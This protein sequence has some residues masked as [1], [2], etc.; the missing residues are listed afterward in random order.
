VSVAAAA[1]TLVGAP[2]TDVVASVALVS[3]TVRGVVVGLERPL[4]LVAGPLAALA[5]VALVRGDG[6]AGER[7]RRLLAAS[8]VVVVALLVVAAAGPYTVATAETA[9]EPR[10]TLVTDDTDSMAVAGDDRRGLAARI[11]AEGVPVTNASVGSGA[12]SPVGDVLAANVR[13]NGTVVVAS[14]GRV[15]TGRSLADAGDLARSVNATVALV[16]TDATRTERAVS[17]S[18]PAKTSVGVDNAFLVGVDGVDL[19]GTATTVTVTVD[20][21]RVASERIEGSGAVR[22]T[23]AFESTGSHRVVAEVSGSDGEPA[24]DV[25]RRTVR[26]VE[27]PRILYVSASR[28]P[29]AGYLSELYE[30]DTARSVPDD[31][32][33]Y[34]AVVLQNTPAPEAGNVTALQEFVI[35]GNGLFV[36]GG[37]RAF[38]AG[39][40]DGSAL[41]SMLPVQSGAGEDPG[42]SANVV[43]AVD[44]SGSAR[45]GMTTQKA[46]SLSVLEQ[47]GNANVVG[48]V[49]FN[50][51]AFAVTRPARL[52]RNRGRLEDDVRRLQA[53]GGTSLAAGIRGAREMLGGPGTIILVSDGRDRDGGVPAAAASLERDVRVITV[54]TGNGPN[55]GLLSE[56]A[57]ATGGTYVRADQTTRLRLLFGEADRTVAGERLTVVDGASF[58]TSGVTL[59]SNPGFANDVSVKPGADYLVATPEGTPAV[60]SWRYGLGRVVTVTSY[61]ARDTLDGLLSR[62]DS[63]LVTK[64]TNYAIGDPE[65]R[66][67]DVAE[68]PDTRVGVPTTITYRGAERPTADSAEF[69][70]VGEGRFEATVTPRQPGFRRV[71]DARFAVDAHPEYAAYGTDPDLLAVVESTGGRTFAPDEAAAIADYARD[72]A[73]GVREVRRS[74]AWLALLAGLLVFTGEVVVRRVQVYRGRSNTESGLA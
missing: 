60:A 66:A 29:L 19:D 8:R 35:D 50:D 28:Y 41:G 32:S 36:A 39:D 47:L 71:L 21:E 20:G 11:E 14:D 58:V 24:N 10:V 65:R 53:G 62:P 67:S 38:E 57:R 52:S 25:A 43:L 27:R 68:A 45:Q 15:T 64:A 55:E 4:A 56:V 69:R 51:R 1:A 33:P 31:L 37:S 2:A 16:A 74:W 17:L 73:R 70:Q 63:L 5:V 44:I 61:D 22:V 46:V 54:G 42:A 34:Y 59:E 18:G 40:Y 48:L 9:G 13:E 49:A 26:V 72:R 12:G 3:T 23:H 7:S 30:V 6:T